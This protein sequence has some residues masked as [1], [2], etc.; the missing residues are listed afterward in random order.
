[1]PAS[2]GGQ[3]VAHSARIALTLL[4]GVET[5]LGVTAL[6]PLLIGF[7]GSGDEL[8][9]QRVSVMLAGV[10]AVAWVA[11]T[12]LGALRRSGRWPRG[13]ALTLHVL[14]FAAGTGMLRYQLA[15]FWMSAL[16]VLLALLGFFAALLAR[17]GI[18]AGQEEPSAP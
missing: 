3:I 12:F 1:M 17:E 13:S 9:G 4:L 14:M 7:T 10:I 2:P 5:A 8:L 18:G 15:P 16:V 11:V 6:V